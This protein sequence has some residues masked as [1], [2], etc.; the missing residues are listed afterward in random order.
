[1]TMLT[2]FPRTKATI[3]LASVLAV[4]LIWGAVASAS[5]GG[6]DGEA[7]VAQPVAPAPS[8]APAPEPPPVV[9]RRVVVVR[10][11]ASAP[12]PAKQSAPQPPPQP[13]PITKSQG[14]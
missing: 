2:K 9:I 3:L 14:S 12:A 13:Q 4:A 11:A 7:T 5:P 6:A 10:R 1:M 8:P